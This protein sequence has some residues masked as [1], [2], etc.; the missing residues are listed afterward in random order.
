MFIV[1]SKADIKVNLI[2]SSVLERKIIKKV[3]TENKIRYRSTLL[4]NSL[5][6]NA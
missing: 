3:E 4:T 2:Y 5:S 6:L 1:N